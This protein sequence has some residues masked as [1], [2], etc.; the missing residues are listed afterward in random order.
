MQCHRARKHGYKN[1]LRRKVEGTTCACC[2]Y[3]YSSRER[4]LYHL[5]R[6]RRCREH[7]EE[8]IDDIPEETTRG[9][10]AAAAA[11]QRSNLRNGLQ[12][13]FAHTPPHRCEG[14]LVMPFHFEH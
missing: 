9:L 7:Y 11:V 12:P 5:K 2:L 8:V 10:D 14:P 4:L 6:M 1:P 13:R 3:D